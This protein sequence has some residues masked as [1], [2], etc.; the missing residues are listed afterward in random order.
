MGEAVRT[1][2]GGKLKILEVYPYTEFWQSQLTV[3]MSSLVP[4]RVWKKL[5]ID[6]FGIRPDARYSPGR[7]GTTVSGSN[8][9]DPATGKL[10]IYVGG[11]ENDH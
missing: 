10:N 3:E 4:E 8:S 6:N 9:Y 1:P 7:N 2:S 11:N 5:T